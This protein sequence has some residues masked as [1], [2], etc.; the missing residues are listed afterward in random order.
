VPVGDHECANAY[1][2]KARNN[3]Y[4]VEGFPKEVHFNVSRDEKLMA[5][6]AGGGFDL[7]RGN[8][9]Y[10]AV[11]LDFTIDSRDVR[12]IFTVIHPGIHPARPI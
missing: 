11:R 12:R 1:C 2:D 4:C 7:P 5:L 9:V 10:G 6:F 3:T 8:S